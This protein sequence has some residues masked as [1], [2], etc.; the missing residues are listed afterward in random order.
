VIFCVKHIIQLPNPSCAFS[1][2][3][4]KVVDFR[5]NRCLWHGNKI[6]FPPQ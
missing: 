3:V 2:F 5:D 6:T 4:H 1:V